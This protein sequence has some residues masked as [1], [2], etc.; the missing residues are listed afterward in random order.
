MVRPF[1]V[2]KFLVE[3]FARYT[4]R[5]YLC[6]A[7]DTGLCNAQH[8]SCKGS[9]I[10]HAGRIENGPPDSAHMVVETSLNVVSRKLL[11]VVV[12]THARK[13]A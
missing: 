9:Q 6:K 8:I 13:S 7:S 1:F 2:T 10:H 4:K 11:Q 12:D 3:Y 5:K